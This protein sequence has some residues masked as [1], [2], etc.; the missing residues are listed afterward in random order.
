MPKL[1]SDKK[2]VDWAYRSLEFHMQTP[3][4]LEFLNAQLPLPEWELLP[5]HLGKELRVEGKSFYLQLFDNTQETLE[6]SVAGCLL[7]K[8][9]RI[10]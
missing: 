7:I 6:H 2:L 4:S 8:P 5:Y 3:E 1:F 9:E 10:K